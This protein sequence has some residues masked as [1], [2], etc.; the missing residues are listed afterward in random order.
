[1]QQQKTFLFIT[2]QKR[3]KFENILGYDSRDLVL[4]I[5]E[6]NQTLK[7]SCHFPIKGTGTRDLIWLK[8]VSLD[9]SWLVGLTGDI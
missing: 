6:K 3:K 2:L 5:H 1:M 8:V 9:R 7:I 4:S